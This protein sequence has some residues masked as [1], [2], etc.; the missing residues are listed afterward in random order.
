MSRR[1]A[2]RLRSALA[3]L[4]VLLALAGPGAMAA[5]AGG[6]TS[7]TG[8]V[9]VPAAAQTN[10]SPYPDGARL[11]RWNGTGFEPV[12]PGSIHAG[13]AIF[14]SH[15][16]SPGYLDAYRQLQATSPTLVT[17][18]TPGLVSGSGQS[19]LVDF[20][21]LARALQQADPGATVVMFSWV[22]QSATADDPLRARDAELATEVNGHRLAVAVDQALAPD[23]YAGGGQ[24][25]LIGHSFGANVVTTAALAMTRA[26]RQLTL[27]DSPEVELARLGGAKNDLQYKLPR[28]DLGRGPG[29]TFVDNYISLVGQRYSTAPGL[30][31][32][33]D[34]RTA[35]PAGG[36]AEK[37]SFAV[38]WYTD[39]VTSAEPPVGYR[40]SPLAGFDVA[41][42][43]RSYTQATASQPLVLTED[44]GPPPTTVSSTLRIVE[45]PLAA[46]HAAAADLEV[47]GRGL[48][49]ADAAYAT[50]DDSLWL[51]FDT[52]LGGTPGDLLTVFVDGRA[53]W[54]AGVPAAGSGPPGSFV[55]LYDVAPGPHVLSVTVSGPTPT[56]PAGAGTTASLSNLRIASTSGI[57]RN[58]TVA[59]T[60]R[61]AA[62]AVLIVAGLVVG[63]VAGLVVIV[64]E[65][66]RR[67]RGSVSRTGDGR[68]TSA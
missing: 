21:P 56:D 50:D 31:Q 14:L 19:M 46:T 6:S 20:E 48:T 4:L 59:Q 49:T 28:L 7:T 57:V 10:L 35:P 67:R 12:A 47:S 64:I 61:L 55:I 34:V 17:A 66:R 43:G 52:R 30:D 39:S 2:R 5:R 3:G 53:R 44:E 37:H 15:G 36:F 63:A 16:W 41:A 65:L 27:L 11:G 60:D 62:A 1:G 58:L 51:T 68:A 54:Q 40:W 26:P 32:V 8:P 29:Q 25:H 9:G 33:V 22:D 42:L 38:V 13:H 18:W 45:Q 24:V 23:F